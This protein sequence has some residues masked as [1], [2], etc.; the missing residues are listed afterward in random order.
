MTSN[1]VKS[2]HP[3]ITQLYVTKIPGRPGRGRLMYGASVIH[4]A[5]GSTGITH[6]KREGDGATPAGRFKVLKSLFRPDKDLRPCRLPMPAAIRM[7]DAWCDDPQDGQ[8]NRQVKLPFRP[9]HENL[10]RADHL[11][12]LVIVLDYNIH[13]RVSGRGSAIFLHLARPDL[14]P[15]AGCVAIARA[16]MRRLLPHLSQYTVIDIR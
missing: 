14:S 9:R 6:R 13:P 1:R 11:Y 15:T 12:D 3:V 5:L 2:K 10:W 4:C 7:S 8:Y 16:D